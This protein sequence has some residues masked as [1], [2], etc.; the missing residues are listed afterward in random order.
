MLVRIVRF[1]GKIWDDH[2]SCSRP[3]TCVGDMIGR[4]TGRVPAVDPF[5]V[6]VIG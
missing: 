1:Q 3:P 4:D 6:R 2:S 5:R